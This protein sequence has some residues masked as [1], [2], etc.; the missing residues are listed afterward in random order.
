VDEARLE[1]A[2]LVRDQEV[3]TIRSLKSASIALA[4]S[5]TIRVRL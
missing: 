5:E 2:L 1:D 4:K 3:R